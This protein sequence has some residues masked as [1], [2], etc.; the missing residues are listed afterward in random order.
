MK[1]ILNLASFAIMEL[2]SVDFVQEI[3]KTRISERNIFICSDITEQYLH[4]KK[5]NQ[6]RSCNLLFT[7]SYKLNLHLEIQFTWLDY[8]TY[9]IRLYFADH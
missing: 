7:Y 6:L 9:E 5:W 3:S 8:F 1:I 4:P 2:F